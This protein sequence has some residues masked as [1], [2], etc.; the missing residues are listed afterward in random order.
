LSEQIFQVLK[1]R[2][3]FFLENIKSPSDLLRSKTERLGSAIG[4]TE[5]TCLDSYFLAQ[6]QE[7]EAI[8][9]T[10]TQLFPDSVF[11]LDEV[12][13]MAVWISDRLPCHIQEEVIESDQTRL[14]SDQTE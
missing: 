3:W 12:S 11:S 14:N 4:R 2:G 9:E 6:G 1:S 8:Y 5:Q 7:F 13:L 10:F